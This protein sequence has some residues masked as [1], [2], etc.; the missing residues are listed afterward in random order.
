MHEFDIKHWHPITQQMNSSTTTQLQLVFDRI[1]LLTADIGDPNT[2]ILDFIDAIC[3]KLNKRNHY[4]YVLNRNP[5]LQ[6]LLR[7]RYHVSATWNEKTAKVAKL[8]IDS[9]KIK[10]SSMFYDFTLDERI[11]PKCIIELANLKTSDSLIEFFL[12]RCAGSSELHK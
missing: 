12:L 7:G 8:K 2:E 11:K 4:T 1:E 10:F 6:M 9:T 5:R 3:T